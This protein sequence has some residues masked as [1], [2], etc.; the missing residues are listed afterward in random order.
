[1]GKHV[2]TVRR[3]PANQLISKRG[4]YG[5]GHSKFVTTERTT[6]LLRNEYKKHSNG[7]LECGDL[8][9]G[10]VTAIKCSAFVKHKENFT[11]LRKYLNF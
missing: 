10:R 7:T 11:L 1:M 3:I 8:Y 9:C 4:F 5:Y 2:T 6:P